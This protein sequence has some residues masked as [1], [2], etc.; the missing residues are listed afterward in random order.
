MVLVI[1]NTK[2]LLASF[3]YIICHLTQS[4]FSSKK[5]NSDQTL[6]GLCYARFG[7][8]LNTLQAQNIHNM[9]GQSVSG[10]NQDV[11]GHHQDLFGHHQTHISQANGQ[12]GKKEACNSFVLPAIRTLCR[13]VFPHGQGTLPKWGTGRLSCSLFL[14][15]LV[16][17]MAIPWSL[18]SHLLI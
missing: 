7:V 17:G 3:V 8:I 18:T 11:F 9:G 13:F 12:S 6:F 5:M 2:V 1:D 10:H 16:L 4:I 15:P 14:G